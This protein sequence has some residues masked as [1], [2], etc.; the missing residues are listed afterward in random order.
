MM[1]N[2][3]THIYFVL[4]YKTEL[5]SSPRVREYSN[6]LELKS[7]LVS[8]STGRPNGS[9]RIHEFM[10][11]SVHSFFTLYTSARLM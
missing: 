2:H 9:G 7:L 10:L 4:L 5:L 6:P 1:I 8:P 3:A 11:P